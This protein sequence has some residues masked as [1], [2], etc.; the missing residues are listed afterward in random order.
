ME[1][2]KNLTLIE[3][4]I[5][6]SIFG[7]LLAIFIPIANFCKMPVNNSNGVIVDKRYVAP[8]TSTTYNKVGDVMVPQTTHYEAEYKILIDVDGERDYVNVNPD[9]YNKAKIN[10]WLS[11]S[12]QKGRLFGGIRITT[13]KGEI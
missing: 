5:I 13:I 11:V 9:Y 3:W 4:L 1:L 2:F 6:V 8:H 12:Y 10:T 7:I